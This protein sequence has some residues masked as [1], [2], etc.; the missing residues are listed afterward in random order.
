[1]TSRTRETVLNVWL[2]EELRK[3]GIDAK[4]ESAQTGNRAI[5]VEVRIGPVLIAVEAKHGQSEAKR[6][7][8][9]YRRG[10]RSAGGAASALRRRRLLPRRHYTRVA[11][12]HRSDVERPRPARLR[13]PWT[14]GDV[15]LRSIAILQPHPRTG[16]SP[17]RAR[18]VRCGG[19]GADGPIR[20][21][22]NPSP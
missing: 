13:H 9:G 4:E 20:Q 17:G 16:C 10:L 15:D 19:V 18:E 12:S 7:E 2:A 11:S 14:S 6:R 3:R 21:R 5:D 1:M 8:R 22:P